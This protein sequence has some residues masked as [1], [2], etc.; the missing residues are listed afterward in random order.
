MDAVT[1]VNQATSYVFPE[2]PVG[3]LNY[4]LPIEGSLRDGARGVAGDGHRRRQGS[5]IESRYTVMTTCHYT[6]CDLWVFIRGC[7]RRLC[8]HCFDAR[9][10]ACVQDSFLREETGK[11]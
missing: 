4:Q 5:G 9:R 2:R 3:N 7:E 11:I 6:A 1:A 10:L 8:L